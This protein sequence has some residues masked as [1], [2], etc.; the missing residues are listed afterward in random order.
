MD[1]YKDISRADD[2][3]IEH[4]KERLKEYGRQMFESMS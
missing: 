1:L 3:I 2:I 4:F